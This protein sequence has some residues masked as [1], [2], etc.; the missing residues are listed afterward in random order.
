MALTVILYF[1]M[2]QESYHRRFL[3]HIDYV[4]NLVGIDYVGLG[5]DFDGIDFYT[6]GLEDVSAIKNSILI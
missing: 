2:N 4:V 3:L 1:L 5:C 6:E